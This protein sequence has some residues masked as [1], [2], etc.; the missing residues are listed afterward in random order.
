MNPKNDKTTF[1]EGCRLRVDGNGSVTA[2]IAISSAGQSHETMVATLV[3][4]ELGCD[5]ATV[6]VVRA[7]SLTGLPSQSPV[8][9]RMTIVLGRGSDRGA[10]AS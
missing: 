1:P 7:D 5:P 8:G 10:A 4:E 9:S 2:V 6:T 3:A